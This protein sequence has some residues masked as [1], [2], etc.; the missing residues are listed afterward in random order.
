M[1]QPGDA[2]LAAVSG[3]PDSVALLYILREASS[4]YSLR[5]A[6]AHLHH[7]LRGAEADRDACFVKSLTEK[8]NVPCYAGKEDV[9]AYQQTLRIS[10][11]EAAR[12]VR[13]RFLS[14]AAEKHGFDKIALGHHGDDAAELILMNLLR[15]SGPAGLTGIPPVR[16][17]RYVRPL[18]DLSRA[19]ILGF[20]EE[21]RIG[22]VSDSSN[23]D[24]RH[25]RN[26]IRHHLIPELKKSY[27]P[28]IT[29]TLNRLA[30]ILK[31]E[32]AWAGQMA[33]SLMQ[34]CQVETGKNYVVLSIPIL[35]GLPIAARRRVIRK[36]VERVK[37]GLRRIAFA[38]V[39]DIL[40]LLQKQGGPGQIHL[41]DRIRAAASGQTLRIFKKEPAQPEDEAI[42]FDHILPGPGTC[43][44]V[45]IGRILELSQVHIKDINEVRPAGENAAFFDMETILFPL[46]A[47]NFKPGDR[48]HPLG[49]GGSQKVKKFFIDHKIPLDERRRCPMLLSR[50]Q[51]IWVGGHRIDDHV[52][53]TSGTRKVLKAE[54]LEINERTVG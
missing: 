11:E 46:K 54:L 32:E 48:F 53:V 28:N 9:R 35:C 29:Q 39:D 3:G 42:S 13:Y 10:L 52:K 6:A 25:L 21:K 27:N 18:S 41:P 50:D 17:G 1:F 45:E 40:N 38:H 16:E 2:V 43:H 24:P 36:A 33:D 7:G 51:I 12:E 4:R 37:G 20:L 26:R 14:E 44:L 22:Y 8:L 49:T 31:D 5:L 19:D 30:L 23:Q 34:D 47:R 15:G